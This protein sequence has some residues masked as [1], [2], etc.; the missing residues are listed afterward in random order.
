MGVFKGECEER[1][2]AKEGRVSALSCAL[3]SPLPCDT[4]RMHAII[5]EL[6]AIIRCHFC[7]SEVFLVATPVS[8][9]T[10]SCQSLRWE[11]TDLH[12]D[13]QTSAGDRPWVQF[14]LLQFKAR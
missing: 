14:R 3:L 2:S 10:R 13:R 7:P 11:P 6:L 9:S 1:A 4:T 5:I 12:N 8:F